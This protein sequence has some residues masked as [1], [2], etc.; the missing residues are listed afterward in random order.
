M[1]RHLA[2]E[3]CPVV[4]FEQIERHVV[5]P[6]V[7]QPR[8]V[9]EGLRLALIRKAEDQIGRHAPE[10]DRARRVD[11]GRGGRSIV[12]TSQHPE[13]GVVERLNAHR[14]AVEPGADEGGG[15]A[16]IEILGVRLDRDLGARRH[17]EGG[18]QRRQEAGQRRGPESRRRSATE[19][20]GVGRA[21]WLPPA[22]RVDL[23]RESH[24][25]RLQIASARRRH[26]VE[27]AVAAPDGAVRDVQVEA[28][29]TRSMEE[30]GTQPL[31]PL[32]RLT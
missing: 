28:D 23:G 16:P 13:Q 5:D 4:R 24:S 17:L 30:D 27:I 26:Q 25:E 19:V 1:E 9:G 11:R 12:R 21:S 15:A 32:D 8:H 10:A 2:S 31:R 29:H 20:D 22:G 7:G 6:G 3:T 14:H 18:A